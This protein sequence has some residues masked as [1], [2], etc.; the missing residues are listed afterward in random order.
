[1]LQKNRFES[2]FR[3]NA[4]PLISAPL[5]VRSVGRCVLRQP[6]KEQRRQKWFVQLF[7]TISGSGEFHH[8]NKWHRCEPNDVFLYYPGDFHE[9]RTEG[10]WAYYWITFDSAES[11]KW[12]R[13]F[14]FNDRVH[15]AGPCPEALFSAIKSALGDCT[16]ESERKS[17][18]LAYSLLLT[19]SSSRSATEPAPLAALAKDLFDQHFADPRWDV[20]TVAA[21]LGIHRSTLYRLFQ[22]HYGI[23]PSHFLRNK[24]IQKALFLLSETTWQ[25]QEIARQSGFSDPNYFARAMREVIGLQPRLFQKQQPHIFIQKKP[26]D[27]LKEEST[28]DTRRKAKKR[29]R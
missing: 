13:G 20:S 27:P 22:T 11:E 12:I 7:W 23:T 14:G 28:P 26:A 9:I 15:R 17:S 16:L 3:P 8:G 29:C 1:M 25:I 24:R 2:V 18:E 21:Q 5:C 10:N 6:W 19:A 4:R